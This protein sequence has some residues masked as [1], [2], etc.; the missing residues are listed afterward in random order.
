MPMACKGLAKLIEE[1]GELSQVAGKKLVYF[2]GE[3]R[4]PDGSLLNEKFEE[5]IADVQA[6]IDFVISKFNLRKARINGRRR[7][8]LN[9]FI[10]WDRQS[11]NNKRGVDRIQEGT[12]PSPDTRDVREL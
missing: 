7:Y 2:H 3:E 1:L 9:R 4:H 8:K 6:S 12:D 10:G 5:E 11:D